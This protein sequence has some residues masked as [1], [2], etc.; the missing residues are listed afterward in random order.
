MRLQAAVG[1]GT[2]RHS[3]FSAIALSPIVAGRFRMYA[4]GSL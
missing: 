1:S 3:D 4:L 2:N